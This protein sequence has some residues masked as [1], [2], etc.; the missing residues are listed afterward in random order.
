MFTSLFHG[1]PKFLVGYAP[2]FSRRIPDEESFDV[3]ADY[4][5]VRRELLVRFVPFQHPWQTL[6][7]YDELVFS[8]FGRFKF[9]A[10]TPATSRVCDRG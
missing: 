3:G 4:G 6:G 2:V 5:E 10:P 1:F 8:I 7:N 9:A